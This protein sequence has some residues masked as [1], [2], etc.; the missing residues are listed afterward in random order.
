MSPDEGHELFK[1]LQESYRQIANQGSA[2]VPTAQDATIRE[3]FLLGRQVA[4]QLDAT[5]LAALQKEILAE[6]DKLIGSGLKGEQLATRM[7]ELIR[8]AQQ[9]VATVV[10]PQTYRQLTGLQP[11]E[12]LNIVDPKIAGQ[13]E[14]ERGRRSGKP[15]DQPPAPGDRSDPGQ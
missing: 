4:S 14:K 6:R 15:S 12:T 8:R 13:I 2:G 1:Q 5:I 7:N 3:T 9:T 11:G 10:G